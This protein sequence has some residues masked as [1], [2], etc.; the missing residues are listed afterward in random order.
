VNG[1]V[2]SPYSEFGGSMTVTCNEGVNF[3]FF[4]DRSLVLRVLAIRALDYAILLREID[5]AL[6]LVRCKCSMN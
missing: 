1:V 5:L 6:F 2:S 3:F 4:S